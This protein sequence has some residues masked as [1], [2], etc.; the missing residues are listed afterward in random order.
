M[1]TL[2]DPVEMVSSS[3]MPVA[4]RD[5]GAPPRAARSLQGDAPRAS[6]PSIDPE[7]Q[8]QWFSRVFEDEPATSLDIEISWDEEGGDTEPTLVL[9][10]RTHS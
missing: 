9:R 3:H 5:G 1:D 4:K 8:V 6:F 10:R 7:A 2:V